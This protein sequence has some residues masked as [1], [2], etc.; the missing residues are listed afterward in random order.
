MLQGREI[1]L[2]KRAQRLLA[3][4]TAMM[5]MVTEYG[6][7]RDMIA[8]PASDRDFLRNEEVPPRRWRIWI[9]AHSNKTFPLYSHFVSEF[10]EKK[11][12]GNPEGLS[13][14]PNTQTSTICV[15]EHLLIFVLSSSFVG[16][17]IFRTWTLPAQIRPGMQ[18]IWPHSIRTRDV[19]WTTSRRLTDQGVALLANSFFDTATEMAALR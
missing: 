15:G 4:W 8:V 9:G 7:G 19:R 12:E 17:G 1:S 11:T 14:S 13:E 2:H 10:V 5:V 6:E 18:Q 16:R 3:A